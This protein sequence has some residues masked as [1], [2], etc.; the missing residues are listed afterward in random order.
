M[1]HIEHSHTYD[2]TNK[3]NAKQILKMLDTDILAGF[4]LKTNLDLQHLRT[5]NLGKYT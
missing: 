1:K 5:L 4:A 3:I 2:N